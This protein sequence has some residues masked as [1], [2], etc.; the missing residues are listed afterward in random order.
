[1]NVVM[2]VGIVLLVTLS[3][4]AT[5]PV[6]RAQDV[7]QCRSQPCLNQG[8]CVDKGRGRYRCICRRGWTGRR[9]GSVADVNQCLSNPCLNG[10]TCDDRIRSYTCTCPPG[11]T[12]INCQLDIN[13]CDEDPCL[14]GGT[15]VDR[16]N[17]Y[18][19]IC[20]AGFNGTNC[21]IDIDECSSEQCQNGGTC[22]DGINE[23]TCQCVPG[24]TGT[25]CEH[26]INECMS[27]PCL[28]GGKCVDELNQYSCVCQR[29][30]TGNN[31][32]SITCKENEFL[33]DDGVGCVLESYRCDYI[34]DCND[35]SDE[36]GCT[37][38]PSIQFQC[39]SGG[40]VHNS[41]L[42]D[43][44]EDCFDGSD[45]SNDTCDTIDNIDECAS[46]PCW[47]GASCQDSIG[48]FVCLCPQG[49]TGALCEQ[50]IND[51]APDPC[52]NGGICE[53]GVNEY[54]CRCSAGYAGLNCEQVQGCPEPEI[55]IP[56]DT[57]KVNLTSYGYPGNYMNN[58]Q[59]FWTVRCQ[60]GGRILVQFIDFYTETGFDNLYIGTA[61]NG[62]LLRYSG[63]S[64]HDLNIM[65]PADGSAL[66]FE[67]Y[68]D[69]GVTFRGFH[70][71]LT[72][73]NA[74][75][76]VVCP[77]NQL[78]VID[79]SM[80]CD[81]FFDCQDGSDEDILAN[82]NVCGIKPNITLP[83]DGIVFNLTSKNY[84]S[85]YIVN[86][87]S[88]IICQWF[89]TTSAGLGEFQ[90]SGAR[91]SIYIHFVDYVLDTYDAFLYFGRDEANWREVTL[92]GSSLPLDMISPNGSDMIVITFEVGIYALPRRGFYMELSE[93]T[94]EIENVLC[95]NG[96]EIL[97]SEDLICDG[98][99]QCSDR[100]D[101]PLDCDYCGIE[102]N[103]TLPDNGMVFN[104]TSRNYPSNYIT[105]YQKD[106]ICQ[107]FV[108]TSAG[109]RQFQG[110]EPRS[111]IFIH[112]VDFDLYTNYAYL[113]FGRDEANWR[114]VALTGNSLPRD[115]ISPNGTDMIVITFEVN[116]FSSPGRGFYMELSAY[117]DETENVLCDNDWEILG[118]EDLVCDGIYQC[119][120]RSDEPLN[121]DYCG[122]EPNITLPDNGMVFNLTSK[123]YPSNYI[124]NSE[125]DIICQWFVTTSAGLGE[126]QGSGA[127]SSIYIHFVDFSLDT[128]GAF[129][130]FGRD[131]ANWREVALTGSSLPLDMISPNGSDMIVITFEVG[132]DA[133]RGFYVELSEYTDEMDYVLCDNGWEILSSE[134]MI[135]CDGIYQCSDRSDEPLDC[136]CPESEIIIPRDTKVNLT[137]YGYPNN[138]M[139]NMQCF[140]TVQCQEGG[141]ILAQFIDFYTETGFDNL[142]IGTAQNGR[143]LGFTGNS[144]PDLDVLSPADGSALH[145]EFYTDQSITYRG[146]HI[147]LTNINAEDL[148]VCPGNQLEVIDESM[149]CD[150]F[151][152]CQDGSDETILANCTVQP[153]D[154][155]EFQCL[156]GSCIPG[157][158]ECDF[159]R[160]CRYGEDEI[161]CDYCG[162]DANITLPDNGRVFNLTSRNYP[163]NYIINYESDIIC[164]WFVTTSAGLG[165]FQGSGA[166]SSIYIHFVDF[167]LDTHDAF[168]YFERDEAN[169]R[170]VALT[171]NSLP[172]DMISPNG[173]DMIVITFE[174]GRDASPGRGFHMQ[175]Y[176]YT[177]EIDY[178]LCDNGWEILGSED[179]ICDGI[180]Q[181]SD[182]SDEPLDCV[183][184]EPEII[185]PRDTKV[186]LTSYGYPNNYMSNMQCFWTVQCQQGGRI[187]VQ[188]ID[189]YTEDRYDNLYIGP[190]QNG[191][192]LRY[193]GNSLPDMDVLSP[194]NG[195]ALHFEFYTDE[196]TT[197]RG[198]HICLTNINAEDL[199]V[200][201]GNQLEVLDESM[202]CDGFYDCQDGSDETIFD[203]CSIANNTE[204]RLVGGSNNNEGRVEVF[205][206]NV[207]GTVCDD[208]WFVINARVVC[209]QLGLP[210]G[211]VRALH[212][213]TFGQGSGP[214]WLDNVRCTGSESSLDLCNHNG[215]GIHNCEHSDD[216]GVRCV[217]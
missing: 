191:R 21:E 198:F 13:E 86:S 42:C 114:E 5:Q 168:L 159:I 76:L 160:N 187:L 49:Y 189:F 153:C 84:P 210:Y 62:R 118:S 163:S 77:G 122:I 60:E 193:T 143:L 145:F 136:V 131:E 200:C 176:E 172:R 148:V 216:A 29:G 90:G 157:N 199:V 119:L 121:C 59:C 61:Q 11:W 16:M 96:W 81:G 184:P 52:L 30:W 24:Y 83:D 165:E 180:H 129:L 2:D 27:R 112:F 170:E 65:S 79:E 174:V 171:G 138:Y 137:S 124:I 161:N 6:T 58:M 10:A 164:Q 128:Y 8:R 40:C 20:D 117:T 72:N 22:E 150:G 166:R 39:L 25:N 201:P 106:I 88:D 75:D 45:E 101:E 97:G 177:D 94:D 9:C 192:L 140:W 43:D 115:M 195:S 89:V 197:S 99:F 205:H 82:C 116:R 139:S 53:D 98:I 179:L 100:S 15:C 85:N 31:C 102:P 35:N 217:D 152:D 1:M 146:F 70:I 50:N 135:I 190:A 204:I 26:E 63:N 186:N 111:S 55:I 110:S 17:E 169:S 51:C 127:R 109:S 4:L 123:N 209:R 56:R 132:R 105:T 71:C 108:T 207:W 181:C 185:I 203:N 41:W 18:H 57:T 12:G 202:L 36:S 92:T 147:C 64:P 212:T 196:S 134:D 95:D 130:Y 78:E 194:A 104:L 133:S 156:E 183:C 167:D 178:V 46:E 149:I 80:V 182:R 103:I 3:L 155:G 54:Q 44:F 32:Q 74:E 14:N 67:F 66:H 37:C 125:S 38:I 69:T 33:C 19:C 126:F 213:A 206:D 208:F 73:I 151:L 23:Y 7:S 28:N 154:P 87:E 68:T 91:S 47:N 144:L 34:P 173:T 211:A 107:W 113:Y 214:I 93:Y 215:W 141:R 175:L 120:D 158:P 48:R 142:Y 188:F 162:I